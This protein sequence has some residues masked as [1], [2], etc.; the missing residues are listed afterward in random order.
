[1]GVTLNGTLRCANAEEAARVFKALDEHIRLT[2]EEQG[3]ISFE[4]TP[5]DDPLI[6]AVA[7]EFTDPAAFE[8]HQTRAG[9]SD[10]ARLTAGIER[11]Y[12]I[13]GMP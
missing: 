8:A 7:E 4:V 11:D 5:T 12:T 13:K 10:W 3:C 2:R 9:A 1:M 6:W